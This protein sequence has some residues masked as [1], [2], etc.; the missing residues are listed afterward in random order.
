MFSIIPNMKIV[1]AMQ[2]ILQAIGEHWLVKW[3]V[4]VSAHD[5]EASGG[6]SIKVYV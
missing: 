1:I 4:G 6:D 3:N 5:P 2:V